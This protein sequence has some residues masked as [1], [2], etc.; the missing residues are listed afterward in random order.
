MAAAGFALTQALLRLLRT[1]YNNLLIES[2]LIAQQPRLLSFYLF[3][4]TATMIYLF[5]S[6][7]AQQPC[8]YLFCL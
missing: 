5:I 3:Y 8:F 6:L 4:V 2:S 1:V 7:I